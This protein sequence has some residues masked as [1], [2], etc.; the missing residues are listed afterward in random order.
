M[1]L[2][3]KVAII[4]GAGGGLGVAIAKLF[5]A[6]GAQLVLTEIDEVALSATLEQLPNATGI[7]H[8]VASEDGWIKVL[9][10]T[11]EKHGTLDILVNNAGVYTVLPLD[12][13]SVEK[14][15]NTVNINQTG[16]FL[17]M[18]H[19]ARAMN[20]GSSIVNI[21]SVNGVR[22]GAFHT[23]YCATKF[24]VCG[25]TKAA[26]IELAEKGVRV[27]SVHPGG[28]KTRM[29][30]EGAS[31]EGVVPLAR[32][33]EPEEIGQVALFLASDESSYCT[34]SEFVVDGGLSC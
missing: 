25:M 16:C 9:K 13:L 26:A 15:M 3:N 34:G 18:K 17:G 20:R 7:I 32:W 33:A 8:D 2:K 6:Q 30:P 28:I 22:G 12:D 31:A 23:A 19:A 24:A 1:R 21:S 5:S 14:Y 4:T 29:L 27:N 10:D 11:E